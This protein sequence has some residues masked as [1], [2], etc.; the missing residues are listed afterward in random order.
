[1]GLVAVGL[2][3][4]FVVYGCD[5]LFIWLRLVRLSVL[6]FMVLVTRGIVVLGGGCLLVVYVVLGGAC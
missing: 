4:R 2:L 3:W 1:M 6:W 5:C